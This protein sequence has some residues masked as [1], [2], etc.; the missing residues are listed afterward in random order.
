MLKL[1]NIFVNIVR[2]VCPG[3]GYIE[4]EI[5][6]GWV[7]Y[8]KERLRASQSLTRMSR[9]LIEQLEILMRKTHQLFWGLNEL[10]SVVSHLRSKLG[11]TKLGLTLLNLILLRPL[12]PYSTC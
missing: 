9:E 5:P 12:S 6:I 11:P 7:L 2:D 4:L 1:F 10:P 3:C 8:D